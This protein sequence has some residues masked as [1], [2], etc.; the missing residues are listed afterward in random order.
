M[1]TTHILIRPGGAHLTRTSLLNMKWTITKA[2]GLVIISATII[3][4]LLGSPIAYLKQWVFETGVFDLLGNQ[5]RLMIETYFTLIVNT[6]ILILFLSIGLKKIVINPLNKMIDKIE[7]MSEGEQIDL[8]ERVDI[9]SSNE[10]GRLADSYN[11]LI[12][13]LEAVITAVRTS[14]DQ[15]ATSSESMVAAVRQIDAIASEIS[16][17]SDKVAKEAYTGTKAMQDTTEALLEMSS[18]IQIAGNKAEKSS[19]NSKS[20]LSSAEAGKNK[21]EDVLGRM[22]GI[23]RRTEATKQHIDELD[24]Y[25]KQIHQI[26]DVITSISEQTNL[27]ALNASIEAA[28]AGDAGKGFAVVADEVRKLAE[29]SNKEAVQVTEVARHITKT[30]EG[31]VGRMDANAYEVEEGVGAAREAGKALN[32][33]LSSVET[34][35]AEIENITDITNEEIATSDKILKLIESLSTFVDNTATNADQVSTAVEETASSVRGISEQTG[36]LL[37]SSNGLKKTISSF[38]THSDEGAD[39]HARTS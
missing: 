27:L 30:T 37:S 31:V 13:H 26:V 7:T 32:D 25:T 8:T 29:Q 36:E 39:P 2:M 10:I 33:I 9:S 21:V 35:V 34:N 23:Q 11:R 5:L 17:T 4:L 15:T 38:H 24:H 14:T 28:R 22:D 3:S 18:L 19:L 12:D 20:T 6:L 1:N 16:T